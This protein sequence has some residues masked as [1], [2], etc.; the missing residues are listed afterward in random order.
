MSA[1]KQR[2]KDATQSS[3]KYSLRLRGFAFTRWEL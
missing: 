2:S 1:K 3:K